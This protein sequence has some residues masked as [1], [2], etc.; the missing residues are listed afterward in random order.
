MTDQIQTSK[1]AE[2]A[3]NLSRVDAVP[4]YSQLKQRLLAEIGDGTYVEGGLLPT[5]TQLCE[6]YGVSRIT[7]RR[8]ISELQDEGVLEKRAGKGTFVSVQRIVTSLVKLNGF[9]ETYSAIRADPHN[10]LLSCE[11][12]PAD[13]ATAAAL[14]LAPMTP[15]LLVRRLIRTRKGPLSVDQSYFELAR[16]PGLAEELHDD[17]SLYGLLRQKYGV[18]LVHS[19][20]HIN[21]R[22]AGQSDR[23]ILGCKLGEPLF[24]ME[25]IVYDAAM[26]PL[27]RSLLVT[28]TNRITYTIDV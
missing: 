12:L 11:T 18:E 2:P 21:V 5:E 8:A 13:K 14:Q 20:R 10:Q 24:D 27:Q 22:L 9:T 26:L 19:R 7:V 28:P 25:K 16:F 3:E 15:V 6:I 1:V 23:Q 17:V 4:L